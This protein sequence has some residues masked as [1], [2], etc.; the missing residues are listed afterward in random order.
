MAQANIN[1]SVGNNTFSKSKVYNNI[2][3][4]VQEIDNTDGFINILSVSTTK[5][6]NTVS[7][8]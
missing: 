6:A 2:Y 3:E 4:N 1:L 7:N 5:G 8:K